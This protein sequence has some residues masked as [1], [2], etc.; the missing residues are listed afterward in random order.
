M[1]FSK[2]KPQQLLVFPAVPRRLLVQVVPRLGLLVQVVQ[3]VQPTGTSRPQ[4]SVSAGRLVGMG[5]PQVGVVNFTR[6]TLTLGQCGR[7]TLGGDYPPKVV[8]SYYPRW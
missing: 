3:T 1:F 7:I 5:R 6:I 8:W 4:T 2:E